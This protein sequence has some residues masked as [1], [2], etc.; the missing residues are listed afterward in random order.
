MKRAFLVQCLGYW[1]RG[2]TLRDAAQNCYRAGASKGSRCVVDLV[3]GDD[4]PEVTNDG[5]N[6]TTEEGATILRIGKWFKIGNLLSLE[7]EKND[8]ET[9]I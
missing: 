9:D 8:N 7:E 4:T 6:L 1:G 5:M 3:I 2:K